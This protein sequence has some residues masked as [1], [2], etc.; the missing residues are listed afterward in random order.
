MRRARVAT[1]LCSEEIRRYSRHLIVPEVGLVGPFS[2]ELV[3]GLGL[4]VL[5]SAPGALVSDDAGCE[6]EG[7]GSGCAEALVEG[8]GEVEGDAG[9]ESLTVGEE[10]FL[11]A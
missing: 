6:V 3:V 1:Q 2:G 9:A 4:E 8:E 5:G 10:L 7:E 11:P